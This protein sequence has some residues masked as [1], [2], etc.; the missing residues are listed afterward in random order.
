MEFLLIF[1]GCIILL[2][3]F[4]VAVTISTVSS[5]LGTVADEL[6]IDKD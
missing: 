5:T 6:N 1:F 3:L 4:V 2:V